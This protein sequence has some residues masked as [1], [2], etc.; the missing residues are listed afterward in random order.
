MKTLCF[1][2]FSQLILS[3]N[4]WRIWMAILVL[5]GLK[6]KLSMLNIWCHFNDKLENEKGENFDW[7]TKVLTGGKKSISQPEFCLIASLNGKSAKKSQM[8]FKILFTKLSSIVGLYCLEKVSTIWWAQ[9]DH[10]CLA[11]LTRFTLVLVKK[12]EKVTF[13]LQAKR[14]SAIAFWRR[15]REKFGGN[16]RI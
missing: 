11:L 15:S 10:A 2:K 12:R 8:F 9:S 6:Q 4:V 16:T 14:G 13:V 1:I 7:V 5:K 3:G